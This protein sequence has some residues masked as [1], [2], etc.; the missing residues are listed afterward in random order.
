MKRT[1][2]VGLAALGLSLVSL[3]LLRLAVQPTGI[4]SPTYALG[5]AYFATFSLLV[6]GGS[7]GT[8]ALLGFQR[9]LKSQRAT[10]KK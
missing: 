8:A 4:S 3:L 5:L 9:A 6:F 10:Q 1:C 2:L 7:I